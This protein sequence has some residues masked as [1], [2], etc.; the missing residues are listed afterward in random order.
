MPSPP[1]AL[2]AGLCVGDRE[3]RADC[4]CGELI[5]RIAAGAVRKLL[6]VELLGHTRLPFAGHR[7]DHRAGVELA[8]IDVHFMTT[9]R[10]ATA[11]RRCQADPKVVIA[12]PQ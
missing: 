1:A 7:P 12:F 5:D 10:I 9:L 6:F 8:A 3:P 11:G 2:A 4:E